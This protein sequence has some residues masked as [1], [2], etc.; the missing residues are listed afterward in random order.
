MFA[1]KAMES[2]IMRFFRTV[3]IFLVKEL[4][5]YIRSLLKDPGNSSPVEG[6]ELRGPKPYSDTLDIFN[7]FHHSTGYTKIQGYIFS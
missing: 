6:F 4:H 1:F 7:G 5:I 3:Y 2:L